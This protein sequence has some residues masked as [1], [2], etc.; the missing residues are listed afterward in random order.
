MNIVSVQRASIKLGDIPINAYRLTK[1][2]GTFTDVLA[3]K[4][5]TDAVGEHDS[6]LPRTFS[7]KALKDLPNKD[8]SLPHR[9]KAD[10]GESFTPVSVKDAVFYWGK[11]A[12][13]KNQKALA[14]LVASAIES[15]ERRIEAEL[16]K[17][18]A[19]ELTDLVSVTT[20]KLN[21]GFTDNKNAWHD[22]R[23][24]AKIAHPWFQE[25]C[26]RHKY[27]ADQVH[28]LMT[29]GLFG[30]TAEMA[31]KKP[32]VDDSLDPEIGLNHQE[33]AAKM[34]LLA[35]AKRLF[36]G[37]RKGTWQEKVRRAVKE[38]IR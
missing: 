32:L 34:A 12:E 27:P 37:Y 30:D 33:D 22:K 21:Q 17:K 6:T 13:N 36:A 9:I 25:A 5:I 2:D 29:L 15:I 16:L 26:K 8:L 10:T 4:N 19:P 11:M 3:G 18:K 20:D 1:N 14:L 23:D 24:D 31:R 35:R 7:I 38:A 28:D